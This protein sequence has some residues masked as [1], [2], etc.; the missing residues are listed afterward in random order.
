MSSS[1]GGN[2]F[3]TV[4]AGGAPGPGSRRSLGDPLASGWLQHYET[5]SRKNR[6]R[7]SKRLR[8]LLGRRRRRRSPAV[9]LLTALGAVL[10]GVVA[11]MLFS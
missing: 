6:K 7:R 1:T 4:A 2:D 5:V 9:L 11:V 8:P 3:P 10:V